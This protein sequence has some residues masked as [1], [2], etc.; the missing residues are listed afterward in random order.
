MRLLDG[1]LHALVGIAEL[2]PEIVIQLVQG[3]FPGTLPLL[4]TSMLTVLI[5]GLLV[6]L[7]LGVFL[8]SFG[9]GTALSLVQTSLW[10]LY[11]A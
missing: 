10:F 2:D 8:G 6:E 9:R 3:R 11:S 4:V 1:F 7:S 5:R